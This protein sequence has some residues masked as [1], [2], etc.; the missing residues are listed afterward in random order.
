MQIAFLQLE[1][2]VGIDNALTFLETDCIWKKLPGA[3]LT[4]LVQQ[5]THARDSGTLPVR[6]K[7]DDIISQINHAVDKFFR[8]RSDA[9]TAGANAPRR[10]LSRELKKYSRIEYNKE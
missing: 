9:G 8:T 2:I 7:D 3:L 10:L 4:Q 6:G 1:I 5:T